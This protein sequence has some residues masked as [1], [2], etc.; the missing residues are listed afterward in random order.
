M[1]RDPVRGEKLR[2][3]RRLRAKRLAANEQAWIKRRLNSLRKRARDNDLP[4]D[5]RSEDFKIPSV[6]P[7]TGLPFVLG[8]GIWHPQ[9]PSFDKKIPELGYVRGNVFIISW[10]ANRLKGECTDPDVFRA[11]AEYIEGRDE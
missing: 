7:V 6:C 11:I 8:L 5:I 10:L 2:A 3:Y 1:V 9:T 4:F